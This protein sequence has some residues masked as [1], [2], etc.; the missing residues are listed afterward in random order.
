M[1]FG[2]HHI[3]KDILWL[4]FHKNRR[5]KPEGKGRELTFEELLTLSKGLKP[6]SPTVSHGWPSASLSLPGRLGDS[7]ILLCAHVRG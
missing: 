4:S 6:G 5:E 3:I 2:M 7:F 1:E